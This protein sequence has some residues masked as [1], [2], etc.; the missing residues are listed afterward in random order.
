MRSH[1]CSRREALCISACPN[2]PRRDW[3]SRGARNVKGPNKVSVQVR[4]ESLA[5][6]SKLARGAFDESSG[7][8]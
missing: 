3:T 1:T 7:R 6:A 4:P 8:N 2:G 5:V